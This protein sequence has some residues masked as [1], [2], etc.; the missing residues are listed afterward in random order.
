MVFKKKWQISIIELENTV[1]KKYKVTRS[2]PDL[3]VSETKFFRNKTDAENQIK[4]W[5]N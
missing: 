5:L 1:G 4:E 3:L 2:I